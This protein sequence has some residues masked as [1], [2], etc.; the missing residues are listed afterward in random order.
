V[1]ATAQPIKTE[2]V[3]EQIGD[4]ERDRRRLLH[5]RETPE[6]PLAIVLLHPHAALHCQVGEHVH[7]CVLAIVRARPSREPQRER[8]WLLVLLRVHR[9]GATTAAAVVGHGG[10]A[11]LPYAFAETSL[12]RIRAI[13]G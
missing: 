8:K 13:S 3:H 4:G 11:G 6:R 1:H 5:T 2:D 9:A 7:A 12:E 10:C